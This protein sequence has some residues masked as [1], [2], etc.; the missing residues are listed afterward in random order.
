M[1]HQEGSTREHTRWPGY[2][3]IVRRVWGGSLVRARN[4]LINPCPVCEARRYERCF[5]WVRASAK[6]NEDEAE[7]APF[8]LPTLMVQA[9]PHRQRLITPDN[10]LEPEVD[11]EAE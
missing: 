6:L 10:D 8:L 3:P 4:P 11:I 2:R 1:S 7:F 9:E 5:R